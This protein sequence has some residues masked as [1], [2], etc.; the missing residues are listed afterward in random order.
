MRKIFDGSFGQVKDAISEKY[1]DNAYKDM[2]KL[3]FGGILLGVFF[4]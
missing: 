1:A 3:K 4:F 2:Q